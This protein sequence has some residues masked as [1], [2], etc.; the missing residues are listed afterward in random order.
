MWNTIIAARI[1]GIR[2]TQLGVR[3]TQTI[4]K[5]VSK[6]SHP[7]PIILQHWQKHALGKR[8]LMDWQACSAL[9]MVSALA[10]S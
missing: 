1:K 2:W 8:L 6:A 5:Q 7:K 9:R 3:W 4:Y 10:P